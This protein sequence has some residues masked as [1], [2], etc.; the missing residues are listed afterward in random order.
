MPSPSS[1]TT[2]IRRAQRA[3]ADSD[4]DLGEIVIVPTAL[5]HPVGAGDG[6]ALELQ[7]LCRL[8][9]PDARLAGG[10]EQQDVSV[11]NL[12]MRAEDGQESCLAGARRTHA[13]ADV[14]RLDLPNVLRLPFRAR[15]QIRPADIERDFF[16]VQR[17]RDTRGLWCIV[18]A[19]DFNDAKLHFLHRKIAVCLAVKAIEDFGCE[20]D[21]LF[22]AAHAEFL[23]APR[24]G[25]IQRGFDLTQVCVHRTAQVHQPPV[26]H[27]LE[28][29]FE[30][31]GFHRAIMPRPLRASR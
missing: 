12:G 29:E 19:A 22:F 26:V 9:H 15:L 11:C 16:V 13:K 4:A 1:D 27:R 5:P 14:V 30:R 31:S 3:L 6:E 8:L 2:A 10:R 17:R 7:I 23:A 24:N 20:F 21:A 25:N 18:L 28:S